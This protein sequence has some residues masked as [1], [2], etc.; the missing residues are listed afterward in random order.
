[1]WMYCAFLNIDRNLVLL[2]SS[3]ELGQ[4]LNLVFYFSFCKGVW[5]LVLNQ[6]L[7]NTGITWLD[8][9]RCSIWTSNYHWYHEANNTSH[10]VKHL[11]QVL[12]RRLWSNCVTRDKSVW[13]LFCSLYP[14]ETPILGY[15]CLE[16]AIPVVKIFTT[17]IGNTQCLKIQ[18]A[19]TSY[20]T[21]FN[22]LDSVMAASKNH[23]LAT[24]SGQ[25]FLLR[26]TTFLSGNDD[27]ILEK[28]MR[29]IEKLWGFL[30]KCFFRNVS[31]TKNACHPESEV[32]KTTNG[33]QNQ[34]GR[35]FWIMAALVTY[36]HASVL[37]FGQEE[38]T[39]ELLQA[40][41]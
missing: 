31:K 7:A 26:T 20:S 18:N 8:A 17:N 5:K 32:Q 37:F 23:V 10:E 34:S 4:E 13:L 14:G 3:S 21:S 41:F 15:G 12:C 11:S 1:M 27:Y 30:I 39:N 19:G 35:A 24:V 33:P 29:F 28:Q 22:W 40:F 16:K 6:T 25:H 9:S 2:F 36:T 38:K